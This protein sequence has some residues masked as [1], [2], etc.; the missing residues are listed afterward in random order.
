[1]QVLLPT[2]CLQNGLGGN[3]TLTFEIRL[4]LPEDSCLTWLGIELKMSSSFE[5]ELMSW[6]D[7]AKIILVGLLLKGQ[8]KTQSFPV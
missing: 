8:I 2:K 5:H 3:L 1:M 7:V 4:K 6:A